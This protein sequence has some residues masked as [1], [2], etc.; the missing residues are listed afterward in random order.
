MS[1]RCDAPMGRRG[2]A[3]RGL[4]KGL[5]CRCCFHQVLESREAGVC[6]MRQVMDVESSII[7]PVVIHLDHFQ[8]ARLHPASHLWGWHAGQPAGSLLVLR[9]NLGFEWRRADIFEG[10]L[11]ALPEGPLGCV[12]GR[13]GRFVV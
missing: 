5:P 13:L 4:P 8:K 2:P 10:S 1:L 6:S 7:S 12:G 3:E 11:D 9:V